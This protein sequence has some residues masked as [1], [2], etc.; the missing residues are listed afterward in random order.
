MA[1]AKLAQ[2]LLLSLLGIPYKLGAEND[3]NS[4]DL[5][6]TFPTATDCAE[7]LQM[8]FTKLGYPQFGDGS[9]LQWA[10][11]HVYIGKPK[12]WPFMGVGA[13]FNNPTHNNNVGHVF[14]NAGKTR[15]GNTWCFESR[16]NAYGGSR[17]TRLRD[18]RHNRGPV[19]LGV[20][21]KLMLDGQPDTLYS[22]HGW[23][24]PST[25]ATQKLLNVFYGRKVVKED[26]EFGNRTQDWVRHFQ[27]D[28]GLFMSGAV[29]GDVL[30]ALRKSSQ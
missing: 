3:P 7:S 28:R 9:W 27:S 25:L 17:L 22:W 5:E 12:N 6:H 2:N 29:T 26:S 20:Y 4:F 11:C 21:P 10:K 15:Y 8:V 16:G 18:M 19:A 30:V 13:L 23:N 24:G 14:A 1:S